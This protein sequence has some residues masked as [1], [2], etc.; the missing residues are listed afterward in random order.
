MVVYK[1]EHDQVKIGVS[2][3]ITISF[4][5]DIDPKALQFILH[6]NKD[7][8]VAPIEAGTTVGQLDMVYKGKVKQS[9]PVVTLAKNNSGSLWQSIKGTFSLWLHRIFS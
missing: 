5:K 3:E 6:K 7:P 9:F 2:K 4:P 8:L 1:G